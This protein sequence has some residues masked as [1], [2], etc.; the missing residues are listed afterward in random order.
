MAYVHT[1]IMGMGKCNYIDS[2]D[3]FFIKLIAK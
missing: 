1:F 3:V 2:R